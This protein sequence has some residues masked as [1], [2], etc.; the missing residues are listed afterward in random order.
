MQYRHLTSRGTC[1]LCGIVEED[2]YH[3]LVACNHACSI[4]EAMRRVWSL[5]CDQLLVNSGKEW[6]LNLLINYNNA[7]RDRVL[8][9]IWHIWQLRNYLTHDKEV[10]PVATTVDYL[11]SY[12]KSIGDASKYNIEEIIKGKMPVAS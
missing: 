3:A 2:I 8:R 7:E 11:E 10:P 1:P 4:W 9:L 5:P 12:M 6:L